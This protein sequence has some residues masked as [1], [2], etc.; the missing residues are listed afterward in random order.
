MQNELAWGE[1][2]EFQNYELKCRE[3][4]INNLNLELEKVVKERDE[5]KDKIAKWEESTKNLDGILNS[6]MSARDKTGLGYSTQLNELS[7]NHETDS[8]NSLSIFDVRSSDEENTPENDRFSKNGYKAVPPPITGN[9]LTP[10]ADI[11]FAGL[12]EYAIRNKII[13]SQTTELNTK[14]SE[15]V[16]K[17]NDANTEKPKSVSE[18]VVSNPKINRDRVII[19]DWN[20]DDEE[21]E[22]EVQTV[23]PETQTVKTR[24]DKSGQNSKKQGIGFRKVKACFVCK[25]TD[26][27]IKDCNFHD[28]KS[29][30]PKLK[31]VVNTGQREGKPVWDNTKRV[32]HQNFS[33]YPH[34]SKTFVPSGVLTRTGLHRPSVS[35]ARPSVSTARPVCTARPSVS[36]ARPV[37][38]ARPSVSTARPSVSTARPVYATRPIYPRMD[39]VR[40]RGSCSPIKR[41]YYTKPAFRP[42]D[43]KQDVK[44]FMVQNMTTAGTRVVVNTCKG[45]LDTNLKKSRWIWRPK[46]NY[47]DHVSKD[48]G[49]FMLKKGNPEILLQDHAVVDSGC[50]SHMTGNKAYLSNYEDFNGGFVAFRSDPK[51]DELNFKLLD[52]S[53]VVLRAPRKDDVYSLDLKNIIPSGGSGEILLAVIK[54]CGLGNK[55]VFDDLDADHGMELH[56][57][58]RKL[59]DEGRHNVLVF[60]RPEVSMLVQILIAAWQEEEVKRKSREVDLDAAQIAKDAEIARLVHEKELAKMEREREERQRQDQA[61]VDYIA[62]LYD[63]VQAKMD[64]SE[65]RKKLHCWKKELDGVDNKPPTRTQLRSLMMT[66]LKH[67]GKYKHNQLNKKTFEEI[68]ALYIKEQERD[69]DSVPIGSERDEKM[70]DKMNKKA[71]DMDKEEVLK[72]ELVIMMHLETA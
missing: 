39:N 18:S 36:T 5:L 55:T 67:T 22:Y 29:Q 49:S 43:L 10:R 51:G 69:A 53:Q 62:S 44:T 1:K 30:E 65:E 66:Y 48:S 33:K 70:I 61:S 15:T 37:C 9:F 13:E 45:K 54:R 28:K 19:E 25:S 14:T 23:R 58:S 42:K 63:E 52:E 7:S 21:E 16:G 32:N 12:D 17:T 46:G 60:A 34:L 11:S 3:I 2:Y 26:H 72:L 68:Q 24:D 41:S 8:E 38:T 31:N 50:S 35:T 47:L 20:S 40:P 6:Q 4:K 56:V 64:A 71:A 57:N 59:W 27:L